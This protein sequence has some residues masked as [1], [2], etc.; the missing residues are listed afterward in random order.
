MSFNA[1]CT[2]RSRIAGIPSVRVRPSPLGISLFRFRNGRYVPETSSSLIRSMKGSTP[3]SSTAPNVTP[4]IPGAPL[5][6]LAAR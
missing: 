2:T 6:A 1:P 3:A 4:S 5:F